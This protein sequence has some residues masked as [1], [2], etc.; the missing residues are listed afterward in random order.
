MARGIWVGFDATRYP[1]LP[2]PTPEVGVVNVTQGESE[3][4]VQLHPA[5]V[6]AVRV[7]EPPPESKI[8]EDGESTVPHVA[9][10]ATKTSPE[11]AWVD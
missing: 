5:K 1:T 8:F 7:P 9:I 11:P 2:E 6:V 10:L 3:V 4:T